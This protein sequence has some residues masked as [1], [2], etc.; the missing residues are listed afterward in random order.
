MSF[1]FPPFGI[2]MS[3]MARATQHYQ[4]CKPFMPQPLV[5]AVMHLQAAICATQNTRSAIVY[6]RHLAL[7]APCDRAHVVGVGGRVAAACGHWCSWYFKNSENLFTN[8]A[9]IVGLCVLSRT[10]PLRCLAVPCHVMPRLAT[11]NH[12]C[13]AWP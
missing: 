3:L 13:R 9:L 5:G 7:N 4:I 1:S 12:A 6:K 2:V 8:G 10:H 11:P